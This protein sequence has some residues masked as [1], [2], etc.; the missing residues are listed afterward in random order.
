M[1]PLEEYA[2]IYWQRS[3]KSILRQVRVQ[4]HY[5]VKIGRYPVTP[6]P[7]KQLSTNGKENQAGVKAS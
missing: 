3:V 4:T 7:C 6:S 2:W 1:D 5:N